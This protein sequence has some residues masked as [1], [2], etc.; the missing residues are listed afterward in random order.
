MELSLTYAR[1]HEAR[2]NKERPRWLTIIRLTR[3]RLVGKQNAKVSKRAKKIYDR[4]E[5]STKEATIPK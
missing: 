3:G 5:T 4:K 2:S 1:Q